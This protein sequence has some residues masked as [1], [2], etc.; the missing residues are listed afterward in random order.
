MPRITP[1]QVI[2]FLNCELPDD[3]CVWPPKVDIRKIKQNEEFLFHRSEILLNNLAKN[4][5]EYA[6]LKGVCKILK[7]DEI[8]FWSPNDNQKAVKEAKERYLQSKKGEN[9]ELKPY[10]SRNGKKS[11]TKED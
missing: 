3:F 6:Y 10:N 5:S 4:E 11:I 8:L 7:D 9:N 2:T 1:E